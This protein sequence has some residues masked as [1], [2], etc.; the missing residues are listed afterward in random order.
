MEIVLVVFDFV[1]NLS[2][3]RVNSEIKYKPT[4][5]GETN[6]LYSRVLLQRQVPFPTPIMSVS[7][8]YQVE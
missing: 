5:G 3:T 8:L 2:R 4:G 1:E 6:V 7:F